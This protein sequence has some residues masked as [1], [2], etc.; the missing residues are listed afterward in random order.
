MTPLRE[1]A[2]NKRVVGAVGPPDELQQAGARVKVPDHPEQIRQWRR[3]RGRPDSIPDRRAGPGQRH[4]GEVMHPLQH[5]AGKD[6]N[7]PLRGHSGGVGNRSRRRR[8]LR[9]DRADDRA[10]SATMTTR[11]VSPLSKIQEP[12]AVASFKVRPGG[13]RFRL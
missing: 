4:D 7:Q 9:K 8:F 6:G 3:S 11:L 1:T 2:T 13:G 12:T 10:S 5:A